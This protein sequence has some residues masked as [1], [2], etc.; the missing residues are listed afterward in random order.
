MKV[1]ELIEALRE[2][3]PE[4][5]VILQGDPEGN[6]YNRAEGAGVVV[7]YAGEVYDMEWTHDECCLD[8]D[9]WEELKRDADKHRCVV[10]P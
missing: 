10:W 4:M 2:M 7:Q 9:A 8:E 3:D 5:E 6:F 1:K